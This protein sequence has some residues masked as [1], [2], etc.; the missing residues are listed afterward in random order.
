MCNKYQDQ[1]LILSKKDAKLF[2]ETLS[3][4][5]PPNPK[6]LKVVKKYNEN[7]VQKR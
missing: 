2:L 7:V 1:L 4:P 5:L 6:L 3:K